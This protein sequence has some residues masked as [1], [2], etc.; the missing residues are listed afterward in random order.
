VSSAQWALAIVKLYVLMFVSV[1]V[2]VNSENE[3]RDTVDI[4]EVTP[5]PAGEVP[6]FTKLLTDLLVMEGENLFLEC[7]VAGNPKPDIRWYLNNQS[8]EITNRTQ[9]T[10]VTQRSLCDCVIQE[11]SCHPDILSTVGGRRCRW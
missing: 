5:E 7:C 4:R 11:S 8:V 6:K 2:A 3:T 1:V 9:V 10:S